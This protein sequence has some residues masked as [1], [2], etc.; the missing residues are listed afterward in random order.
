MSSRTPLARAATALAL[1]TSAAASRPSESACW[2]PSMPCQPRG[3]TLALAGTVTAQGRS[4]SPDQVR[5]RQV[6]FY[7]PRPST[8]VV[9][10][11]LLAARGDT[12]W[13]LSRSGLRRSVTT[14]T[15]SSQEMVRV[16]RHALTPGRGLKWGLLVGLGS[17]LGPMVACSGYDGSDGCAGLIPGSLLF[18]AIVSLLALP[19]F[20]FSAFRRLRRPTAESLARYARF[21]QGPPPDLDIITLAQPDTTPARRQER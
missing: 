1:S 13:V 3:L 7:P 12:A 10:G 4:R 9:S 15:L 16:Q 21:P 6:Q 14:L 11:E 2:H 8:V 17:G 20:E 19:S 18:G 5:G